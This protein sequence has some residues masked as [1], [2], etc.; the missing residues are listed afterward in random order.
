MIA[1]RVRFAASGIASG[2][3]APPRFRQR[4]SWFPLLPLTGTVRIE[5]NRQDAAKGQAM[6]PMRF[7]PVRIGVIGMGAF[8]RLHAQTLAGLAE[9]ELVALVARRQ[10]SL[11]ECGDLLPGVPGWLDLDRVMLE[12]LIGIKRAGADM[13]L[14]YFA[15]RVAEVLGS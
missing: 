3:E 4:V 13:I 15:Q 14:S 8:G 6:S 11:D 12:S 10:V 9:S 1:L 7:D 2:A 5:A